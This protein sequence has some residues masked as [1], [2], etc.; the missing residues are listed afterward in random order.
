MAARIGTTRNG[1]PKLIAVDDRASLSEDAVI[2]VLPTP[3]GYRGGNSH[4]G[5]RGE[6]SCPS[7]GQVAN[8]YGTR[9]HKD[10]DGYYTEDEAA[11]C[12]ACGVDVTLVTS[13]KGAIW[14]GP[15]TYAHPDAGVLP[16]TPANPT[17]LPFPGQILARGRIAQGDAGNMGSGEQFAVLMSAGAVFRTTYSGRLYGGPKSHYYH[18]A[19]DASGVEAATWE[20]RDL[21]GTW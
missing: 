5:D 4:T 11:D 7:R 21:A 8:N 1:A 13:T 20:D 12:A 2:V 14:G 16:S 10:A 18:V 3:I 17:F 19:T 15:S 9:R 6:V